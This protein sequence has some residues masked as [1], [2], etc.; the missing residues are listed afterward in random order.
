[1]GAAQDRAAVFSTS[2]SPTLIISGLSLIL[3]IALM[4]C[5]SG[6]KRS[7]SLLKGQDDYY[8]T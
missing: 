8:H 7:V 3:Q 5:M 6:L 2:R 1:M 4:A